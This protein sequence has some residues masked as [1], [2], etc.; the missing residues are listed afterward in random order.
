M[1]G[2]TNVDLE[3]DKELGVVECAWVMEKGKK[4]ADLA[5]GNGKIRAHEKEYVENQL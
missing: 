5:T 4:A 3:L 2:V 1:A